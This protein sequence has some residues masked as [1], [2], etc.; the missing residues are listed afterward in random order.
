MET[1]KVYMASEEELKDYAKLTE[2]LI[3]LYE[4]ENYT[5][6]KVI[7]KEKCSTMDIETVW[8]LQI[9][10]EIHEKQKKCK[11]V[12][13]QGVNPS[14]T[15]IRSVK[16]YQ[17]GQESLPS[18]PQ[19]ERKVWNKYPVSDSIY[20]VHKSPEN[21]KFDFLKFFTLISLLNQIKPAMEGIHTAYLYFGLLYTYFGQHCEDSVFSSISY[22]HYG[23]DKIWY[24]IYREDEEKFYE[25]IRGKF[26]YLYYLRYGYIYII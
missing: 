7:P 23:A 21:M 6:V 13:N 12:Y 9:E 18:T 17:M 19:T 5:A 26:V 11:N 2:H 25:F 4:K 22:L 24:S 8:D 15:E 20:G 16:D 14:R 1:G 3:Q 10:C